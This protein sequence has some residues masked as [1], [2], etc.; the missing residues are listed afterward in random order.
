MQIEQIRHWRDMRVN[1]NRRVGGWTD[2]RM[3]NAGRGAV[4][5]WQAVWCTTSLAHIK[6]LAIHVEVITMRSPLTTTDGVNSFV[7]NGFINMHRLSVL[8]VFFAPLR[9][10]L[11]GSRKDRQE[12]AKSAKVGCTAA[13]KFL[14]TM[15]YQLSTYIFPRYNE[16]RESAQLDCYNTRTLLPLTLRCGKKWKQVSTTFFM[17]NRTT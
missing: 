14:S 12:D 9:E 11:S 7:M 17:L 3:G 6:G 16:S 1:S 2:R 15:D 4:N 13:C 8:C 5:S 10:P